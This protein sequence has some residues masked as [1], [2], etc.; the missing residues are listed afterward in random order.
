M[1]VSLF[2]RTHCQKKFCS[3]SPTLTQSAPCRLSYSYKV[4]STHFCSYFDAYFFLHVILLKSKTTDMSVWCC[5][6]TVRVSCMY[7]AVAGQYWQS[8]KAYSGSVGLSYLAAQRRDCEETDAVNALASLSVGVLSNKRY[9]HTHTYFPAWRW[10]LLSQLSTHICFSPSPPASPTS[11]WSMTV[12]PCRRIW[13]ITSQ[14]SLSGFGLH[15]K[16]LRSPALS[17]D[18]WRGRVC[19]ATEPRPSALHTHTHTHM[20]IQRHTMLNLLRPA[21][22]APQGWPPLSWSQQHYLQLRNLLKPH[23]RA[24]PEDL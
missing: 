5:Q 20:H 9:T 12:T 24:I 10:R 8:L 23:Q 21:A 19:N 14:N 7:V 13:P 6:V 1:V 18:Q 22:C 4:S 11:Q 3:R 16:S 15:L 17:H 2:C